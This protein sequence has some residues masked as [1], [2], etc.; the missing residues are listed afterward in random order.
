MPPLLPTVFFGMQCALLECGVRGV[1]RVM[2]D[3]DS[4]IDS[5]GSP[6]RQAD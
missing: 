2:T 3:E 4:P 1:Q 5:G 6:S